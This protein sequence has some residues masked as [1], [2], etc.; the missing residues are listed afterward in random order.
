MRIAL[1]VECVETSYANRSSQREPIQTT[2]CCRRYGLS[3]HAPSK[4]THILVIYRCTWRWKRKSRSIHVAVSQRKPPTLFRGSCQVDLHQA[5]LPPSKDGTV[6]RAESL[7]PAG[8]SNPGAV[9]QAYLVWTQHINTR[10]RLNLYPCLS[11][12]RAAQ[13]VSSKEGGNHVHA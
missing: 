5:S 12:Y 8:A 9:Y 10:D 3:Y 2:S 6:L 11:W 1:L 7:L 4:H 13:R